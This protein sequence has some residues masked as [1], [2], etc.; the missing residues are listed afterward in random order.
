M[1][2]LLQDAVASVQDVYPEAA[3]VIL[4][5]VQQLYHENDTHRR[6]LLRADVKVCPPLARRGAAGITENDAS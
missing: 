2:R 1:S 5:E 6:A 3:L 4:N